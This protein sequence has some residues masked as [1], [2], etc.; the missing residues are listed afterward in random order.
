MKKF[1]LRQLSPQSVFTACKPLSDTLCDVGK[2]L[3]SR[4]AKYVGQ[5]VNYRSALA[6]VSYVLYDDNYYIS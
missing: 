6:T 2:A 3:Y 4:P 5:N 1:V